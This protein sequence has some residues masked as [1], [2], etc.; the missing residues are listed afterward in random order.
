MMFR[1]PNVRYGS[2]PEPVT[3]YQRA[4]QTWDDRIGSAREQAKNWRFACF[5]ALALC[6]SMAGGWYWQAARGTVI[7]WVVQVDRLGN[8]QA[9]GPAASNYHPTD[10]VIARDLADIIVWLRGVSVDQID[11]RANWLRAYKF[12]TAKG[13][14]FLNDYAQHN[15]PFARVGKEQVSVDVTSVV[16]ASDQSFR[17]EWVERHYVD[18]SLASTERWNAI[19]TVMIS[20]PRTADGDTLN[21][22]PLGI[23]VDALNWSKELN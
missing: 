8:V 19:V 20:P 21:V 9:S 5:T 2:T 4:Q 15:D 12:F 7:P 3:P 16:R 18:G 1:R 11:M 14:L 10:A 23:Y 22:N 6:A 17:V 13:Q